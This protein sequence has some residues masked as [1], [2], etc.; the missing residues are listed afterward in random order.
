[1]DGEKEEREAKLTERKTW[2]GGGS[3]VTADAMGQTG[4]SGG[5]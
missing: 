1:M 3:E 4:R 5:L 2:G